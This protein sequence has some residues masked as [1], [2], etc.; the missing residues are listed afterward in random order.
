MTA[1]IETVVAPTEQ[2]KLSTPYVAAWAA[3]GLT[4]LAYMASAAVP[5]LTVAVTPDVATT[6]SVVATASSVPAAQPSPEIRQIAPMTTAS[7]QRPRSIV[8]SIAPPAA[9][10]PADGTAAQPKLLNG[11]LSDDVPPKAQV[12]VAVPMV[13]PSAPA[14][15]PPAPAAQPAPVVAASPIVTG[16]LPPTDAAP[17]PAKAAAS[18]RARPATVAAQPKRQPGTA[19]AAPAATGARFGVQLGSDASLDEARATW[20]V[21]SGR[22]PSL[23]QLQPRVVEMDAL[24]SRSYRLSAGPLPS[25]AEAQKVCAELKASGIACRVGGYAGKPF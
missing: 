2:P 6:R 16:S 14:A 15:P 22:A 18:A 10:G 12:V 11:T 7:E 13:Q 17:A 23:E 9:P 8:T 5:A 3:L 25:R 4:A 20:A 1:P 24:G 19:T 21:S